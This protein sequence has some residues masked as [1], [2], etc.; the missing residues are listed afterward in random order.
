[1]EPK[2]VTPLND[3]W[4]KEVRVRKSGPQ[5]GR[6]FPVYTNVDGRTFHSRTQAEK[7]G[8][9]DPTPDGRRKKACTKPA[10]DAADPK[11]KPKQAAKKPKGKRKVNEEED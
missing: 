7:N 4:F 6:P 9:V 3:G 8:C 11:R 5:A 1:M 2:E 10:P